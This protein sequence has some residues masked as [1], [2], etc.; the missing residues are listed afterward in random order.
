MTTALVRGT[1]VALVALIGATPSSAQL[2]NNP[3]YVS[4]SHGTGLSLNGEYA[5]G[6]DDSE[7]TNFIGGRAVIGLG[8]LTIQAGAGGVLFSGDL[9][10]LDNEI[11]YGGAVA[12]NILDLPLVPVSVNVQGGVGI[13]DSDL[14]GKQTTIPLSV[15]VAINVP[16]PLLDIE[17][18]AA[19]RLQIVRVSNGSSS[20]EVGFG[21]SAGINITLPTG[22]GFHAALDW[23]SVDF[24][25]V[26][27]NPVS[28]GAGLHYRI[29]IPGLVPGGIV[30]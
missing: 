20:T 11:T 23:A 26:T 12:L 14:L 5:R 4:P 17:P 6:F 15:G 3:V 9:D 19:P 29:A 2:F 25:G 10:V 28:I 16:A 21:A 27:V 8:P 13:L 30:K 18:W 7:D 1:L 22:L 24:D